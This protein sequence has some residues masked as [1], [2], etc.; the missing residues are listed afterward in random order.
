MDSV[1]Q[2]MTAIQ[3]E[4]LLTAADERVLAQTIE[5]GAEARKRKEAGQKGRSIAMSIQDG[6]AAKD[7][8]I[9]ANLR[10]VVSIARRHKLPPGV[11]LLDLV[12]E[13]NIGLEHAVDKFDWRKGFKFSTYA[14]GWIRQ[15]ISRSLSQRSNLVRLPEKQSASL[16]LALRDSEGG[17]LDNEHARLLS[18]VNPMSLDRRMGDGESTALGDMVA[19]DQPGPEAEALANMDAAR[20]ERLLASLDKRSS[21]AISM[22]FGIGDEPHAC[23]YQEIGRVMGISHEGARLVIE[24]ALRKLRIAARKSARKQPAAA[25]A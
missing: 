2:Y 1:S 12:Q 22:R 23:T 21:K 9:R 25:A 15:A 8:F 16:R 5:R 14:T 13:G 20:V 3:A 10:L 19:D 7:R 4:P 11:D 17:V 18:L 6:E 24:T